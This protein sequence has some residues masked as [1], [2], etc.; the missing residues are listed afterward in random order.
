V[1]AGGSV[2]CW[3]DKPAGVVG[4]ASARQKNKNSWKEKQQKAQVL[5]TRPG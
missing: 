3:E 5:L 1:R 2:W 4:A